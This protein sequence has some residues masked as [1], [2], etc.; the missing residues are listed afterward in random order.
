MNPGLAWQ[1]AFLMIP[2]AMLS[3]SISGTYTDL[4]EITMG[5]AHFM[6]GRANHSACFDYLFR[7]LPYH[8][9]YV[10]FSGLEDVLTVL[11]SLHFTDE[12]IYFLKQ[13]QLNDSYIEYLKGFSFSCDVYACAEGE[14]IFPNSPVLRVEGNIIAA[15]LVETM[16]LNILNFESLIATRA[17]R[18][19]QV[20]GNSSLSDFGLRR[21]QGFGGILATRAAAAGGFET[22]SNV[23]GAALYDLPVAGT[24]AHSF[25]QSY[26]DELEAFRA[27]AA[28]RPHDC[29]FLVDTYN[30][31]KSGIPNAITVAKEM[32]AKGYKAKGIRLDSGDLAYL[33]RAARQMLDAAGLHY[34]KI[35]ASNQLDE[36]VIKSL[37]EQRAPIDIFG[38]GTNLVTGKP[39]AALDGVYKL[40][41]AEGRPRLKLSESLEK[42]ILPGVK[43][44]YRVLDDKGMFFGADAVLLAG[45]DPPA[46]TIFHPYDA[47]KFIDVGKLRQEPLL[48]KVMSG[49]KRVLPRTSLKQIAGYAGKRLALLPAE[50]KRFENPHVYKTGISRQLM[51]LRDDLRNRYT[52]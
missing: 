17:A 48:Q 29:I 21:A 50:Y 27:F 9:G 5:E 38:V 32:E 10:V 28:V 1:T 47:T 12:D 18:I 44:V 22:T 19:K 6:Q 51:Q 2:L 43:Q 3:F 14:V 33:S 40:T 46:G 15:Q 34:L 36:F 30:T 23:Y 42:T 7:K 31:L 4:Y 26:D 20:A 11:E 49:G 24:M 35:A 39:D 16:L 52:R 37:Q 41:M 13:L 25:V 45:E 8:G